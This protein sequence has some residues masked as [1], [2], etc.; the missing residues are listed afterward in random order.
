VDPAFAALVARTAA[1]RYSEPL[2]SQSDGSMQREHY[3]LMRVTNRRPG[4]CSGLV[5]L[6]IC[7]PTTAPSE[8]KP[9]P[10]PF[11][12]SRPYCLC[13]RIR[14]GCGGGRADSERP[15]RLGSV[16]SRRCDPRS[17][18]AAAHAVAGP[19]CWLLRV[20]PAVPDFAQRGS[21]R[22]E[23][24]AAASRPKL[25]RLSGYAGCASVLAGRGSRKG[26]PSRRASRGPSP[27]QAGRWL[28][29]M[30]RPYH[31]PL[32]VKLILVH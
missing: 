30:R 31:Q 20:W 3:P 11:S 6:S 5:G 10:T 17:P 4:T 25:R 29:C 32:P 12:D 16:P 13:R 19:V 14:L 2:S 21:L 8:P 7:E 22:N 24:D 27:P 18:Q 1:S 28:T 9:R 23:C 26:Q 15:L